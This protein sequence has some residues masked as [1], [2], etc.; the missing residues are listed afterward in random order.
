MNAD[1][2]L[3]PFV[4]KRAASAFGKSITQGDAA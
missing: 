4:A 1:A 3:F 2:A